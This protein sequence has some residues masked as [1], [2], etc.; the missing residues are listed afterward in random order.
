MIILT[1]STGRFEHEL[2]SILAA[3][4]ANKNYNNYFYTG[5]GVMIGW[6]IGN[7][8][9]WVGFIVVI[10]WIVQRCAA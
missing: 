6:L 10:L 8:I 3:C 7:L 1:M 4:G 9:W 2:G 5:D